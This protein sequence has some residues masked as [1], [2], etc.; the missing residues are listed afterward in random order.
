MLCL[1]IHFVSVGKMMVLLLE[2]ILAPENYRLLRSREEDQV[3]T[4]GEAVL[5]EISCMR[6]G[7]M[8]SACV[9]KHTL[10]VWVSN[11]VSKAQR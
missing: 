1:C 11:S 10:T 8:H 4:Q 6:T 2:P 9:S 7:D 5:T 3:R